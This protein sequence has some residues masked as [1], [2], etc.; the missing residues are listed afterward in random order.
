MHLKILGA[1]LL[2][3]LMLITG[4]DITKQKCIQLMKDLFR[5]SKVTLV[6]C[7]DMY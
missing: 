4:E 2:N 1:T 3:V 6:H 7:K 5:A